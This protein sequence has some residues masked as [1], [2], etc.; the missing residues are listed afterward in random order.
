VDLILLIYKNDSLFTTQPVPVV[1]G[2]R[3]PV[4]VPLPRGTKGYRLRP[5]LKTT[6]PAGVNNPGFE[7]WSLKVRHRGAGNFTSLYAVE[8]DAA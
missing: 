4:R 6:N 3:V 8:G 1:P 7:L 2:A 5:V